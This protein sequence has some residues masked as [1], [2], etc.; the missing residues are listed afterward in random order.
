METQDILNSKSVKLLIKG[1]LVIIGLFIVLYCS[2]TVFLLHYVNKFESNK[3][4]EI[5][6]NNE[7]DKSDKNNEIEKKV[8]TSKKNVISNYFEYKIFILILVLLC[9]P[10][11][12]FLIIFLRF[13]CL[14][15]LYYFK[16]SDLSDIEGI[17]LK[18][19]EINSIIE[20]YR[21]M[22]K[23]TNIYRKKKIRQR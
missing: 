17:H 16:L 18:M 12:V 9:L 7:T 4:I 10:I 15:K 2:V 14:L 13:S 5:S 22:T 6:R 21:M 11:L 20:M 23:A 8:V 3:N 19:H 1:S